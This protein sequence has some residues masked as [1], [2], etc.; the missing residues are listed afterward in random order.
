MGVV[1]SWVKS[2]GR[3]T[4]Q[5]VS[6]ILLCI[7]LPLGIGLVCALL[8][9]GV[10][11]LFDSL[12]SA[13]FP[14]N[15]TAAVWVGLALAVW[16]IVFGIKVFRELWAATRIPTLGESSH[17]LS[18]WLGDK[19]W[20]M[21][22][23][24]ASILP[25]RGFPFNTGSK[26]EVLFA[27]EGEYRGRSAVVMYFRLTPGSGDNPVEIDFTIVASFTD[28]D[29]PV[30]VAIPQRGVERLK[31]LVGLQDIDLESVEF[32]RYWRLVGGDQAAAHAIM[33]PTVIARLLESDA[34]DCPISWDANCV[35]AVNEG[36]SQDF[37]RLEAQLNVLTDLA[38]RMPAYQ[39]K[40]GAAGH[41]VNVGELIVQGEP[42]IKADWVEISLT[43][44]S[45]LVFFTT[46]SLGSTNTSPERLLSPALYLAL[47]GLSVVCWS[48]GCIYGWFRRRRI[49]REWAD[50][51]NAERD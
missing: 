35:M 44:G 41:R 25:A 11:F 9:T 42:K 22:A 3:R 28:A 10:K 49:R 29:V 43:L 6:R 47:L 15:I 45:L 40:S 26:Q 31:A 37:G 1:R 51:V 21:I 46:M 24:S 5:R 39:T 7:A 38:D 27:M 8:V 19:G 20:R 48:V 36:L 16:P 23:G 18:Q 2:W 32:N 12:D 4:R 17:A 13:R 50:R 33:Q 14:D 34:R 30:T